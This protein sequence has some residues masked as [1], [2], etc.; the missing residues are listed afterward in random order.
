MSAEIRFR[1]IHARKRFGVRPE[2]HAWAEFAHGGASPCVRAEYVEAAGEW[3]GRKS[4]PS[5]PSP[6]SDTPSIRQGDSSES[7]DCPACASSGQWNIEALR[8]PCPV[9]RRLRHRLLGDGA[10]LR[11]AL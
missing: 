2:P 5:V 11:D 3:L 8:E 1:G 9:Y 4:T 7:S 10:M 6:A